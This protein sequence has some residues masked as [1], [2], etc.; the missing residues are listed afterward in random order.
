MKRG[1]FP[2]QLFI[3]NSNQIQLLNGALTS[4]SNNIRTISMVRWVSPTLG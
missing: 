4:S 2:L 1:G 3:D